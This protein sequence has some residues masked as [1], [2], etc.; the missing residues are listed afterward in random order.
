[1]DNST[2]LNAAISSVTVNRA[3]NNE[4][5]NWNGSSDMKIKF[6]ALT[7]NEVIPLT[8]Q[9]AELQPPAECR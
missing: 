3:H 2:F 8:S 6:R 7:L 4:N 9:D 1:M 5:N